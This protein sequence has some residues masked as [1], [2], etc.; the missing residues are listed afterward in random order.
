M[1]QL[2]IIIFLMFLNPAWSLAEKV[3]GIEY[4]PLMLAVHNNDID[5]VSSL[6]LQNADPNGKNEEGYTPLH[7]AVVSCNLEAAQML[8]K[9]GA[10]QAVA[11]IPPL[12]QVTFCE[13][14]KSL[15]MVN[16]LF[17]YNVP[18]EHITS[19]SVAFLLFRTIETGKDAL[20]SLLIEKGVPVDAWGDEFSPL[21]YA[22]LL[23]NDAS[24]KKLLEAG[25]KSKDVNHLLEQSLSRPTVLSLLLQSGVDP[26]AYIPNPK[27][28][29]SLLKIA[30]NNNEAIRNRDVNNSNNSIKTLKVT[31]PDTLKVLV[32]NGFDVNAT[33]KEGVTPL[34]YAAK[35]GDVDLVR[36]LLNKKANKEIID[37][38][39]RNALDY[40]Q[41]NNH[42][43]IV[44]LLEGKN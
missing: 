8:L 35:I 18:K 36:L 30:I 31:K 2:R 23:G 14:S 17:K 13:D 20:L 22:I 29:F 39:G 10:N 21:E 12:S 16:L 28:G 9:N 3:N 25:A 34:I 42:L 41:L 15:E 26:N 11:V 24:V 19:Q 1:L 7:I 4:T 43:T 27:F 40:A 5:R 32:E 44:K 6:L 38:R 33:T 37:K